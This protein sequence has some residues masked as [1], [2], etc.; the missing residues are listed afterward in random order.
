LEVQRQSRFLK[1]L[2]EAIAIPVFYKDPEGRY[3]GCNRAFEEFFGRSR[4]TVIGRTAVEVFGAELIADDGTLLA[5]LDLPERGT[6]QV[7]E[8]QVFNHRKELR[9]VI[10]SRAVYSGEDGRIAGIV[11]TFMDITERKQAVR[12]TAAKQELEALNQELEGFILSVSHDLRAPLRTLKGF[13]TALLEDYGERFDQGGREYLQALITGSEEMRGLIEGL[14]RLS[15][16]SREELCRESVDLSVMARDV[17]AGLAREE[18]ER[19]VD[20]VIEE[21]MVVWADPRL[22]RVVLENLLSNAW[23][24]TGKL[25]RAEIV[26]R[27]DPAPPP[28]FQTPVY[29]VMDNGAGFDMAFADRLFQ[30]F[31]RLHQ[32]VEFEGTGIGLVTVQRIIQRHGGKIWA[33]SAPGQGARFHFTLPEVSSCALPVL[34]GESR[35][36]SPA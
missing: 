28:G 13:S 2:L 9:D 25:V 15:R 29:L 3:I 17:L 18:P 7:F 10:F 30:P 11:G 12:L 22:I 34:Q 32:A 4:G 20:I 24:Y 35:S 6:A 8:A 36:C 27:R 21:G 31:Q 33:D 19:E 16:H 1:T 14:L 23:K 5:H 26:F